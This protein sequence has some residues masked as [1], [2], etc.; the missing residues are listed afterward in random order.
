[1]TAGSNYSIAPAERTKRTGVIDGLDANERES[2][3]FNTP[4]QLARIAPRP[5]TAR[6]YRTALDFQATLREVSGSKLVIG[7]LSKVKRVRF[8]SIQCDVF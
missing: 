1:V 7:N 5:A 4:L 3:N 2:P 8:R 6:V